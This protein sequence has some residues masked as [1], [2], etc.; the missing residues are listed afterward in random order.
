MSVSSFL[1]VFPCSQT[2]L[3][4]NKLTATFE[5]GANES[6][7]MS[8]EVYKPE[9]FNGAEGEGGVL[10]N[11]AEMHQYY[12]SQT[13]VTQGDH[14]GDGEYAEIS[15]KSCVSSKTVEGK[16]VKEKL[17]PHTVADATQGNR[18]DYHKGNCEG[19]R[20]YAEISTKSCV[21]SK[22]V[23]GKPVKEKL[24]ER[25]L[26]EGGSRDRAAT[27]LGKEKGNTAKW[28]YTSAA[29]ADPYE[30]E[31]DE[32]RQLEE[33]EGDNAASVGRLEGGS[34][35]GFGELGVGES[36]LYDDPDMEVMLYYIASL[37]HGWHVANLDH[38]S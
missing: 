25:T 35:G 5:E 15:L 7:S 3:R 36:H 33:V 24:L 9:H 32:N 1:L 12:I 2:D 19:I 23:E 18:E 20:E 4:L 29:Y 22:P 10:V 37:I 28:L 26:Q 30:E 13:D 38:I 27:S 31:G 16:P 34:G 14:V 21:S 11:S 8:Y 6:K 17:L